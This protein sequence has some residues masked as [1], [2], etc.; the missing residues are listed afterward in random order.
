MDADDFAEHVDH[1]A[2]TRADYRALNLCPATE[3]R[4]HVA[5]VRV[6]HDVLRRAEETLRRDAG[7][8]LRD[9][10]RRCADLGTCFGTVAFRFPVCTDAFR[11]EAYDGE[12]Y[13]KRLVELWGALAETAERECRACMPDGERVHWVLRADPQDVVPSFSGDDNR[14]C[15]VRVRFWLV[16]GRAP[17]E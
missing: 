3:A 7:E 10:L 16:D 15:D 14:R 1:V 11:P 5:F 9:A 12:F 13:Y 17:D 4:R 6:K 8:E 2:Q